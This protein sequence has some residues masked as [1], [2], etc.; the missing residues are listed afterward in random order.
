[1]HIYLNFVQ[2]F[3]SH[4]QSEPVLLIWIEFF[5]VSNIHFRNFFKYKANRIVKLVELYQYYVQHSQNILKFHWTA[6]RFVF[7]CSFLTWSVMFLFTWNKLLLF[8]DLRAQDCLKY[9]KWSV[10]GNHHFIFNV[11]SSHYKVY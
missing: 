9:E 7:I 11:C 6:F 1:M 5:I 4:I 10:N 8:Q 3:L 2:F